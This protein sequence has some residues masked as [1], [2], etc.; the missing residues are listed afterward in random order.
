MRRAVVAGFIG[1]AAAAGLGAWHGCG[2]ETTVV[3]ARHADRAPGQKAD[4]L[5]AEGVARGRELARVLRQAG[6]SA[7]LHSDTQ[8]AAQTA[9][10]LAAAIGVEPRVIPAKDYAAMVDEVRRRPGETVLV[11]GHSNT[12]P[13]IVAE[14]GGPQLPDLGEAEFDALFVLTV[15]RCGWRPARLLRLRYGAATPVE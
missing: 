15:C 1:V 6:V 8:R 14:L 9:A 7:I 3:L 11:I 10:P 5:S 12:V 2:G 4:E 13:A